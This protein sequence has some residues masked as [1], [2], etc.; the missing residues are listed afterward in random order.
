MQIF[1]CGPELLLLGEKEKLQCTKAGLGTAKS[2]C[3]FSSRRS[4]SQNSYENVVQSSGTGTFS[5]FSLYTFLT[6][7]SQTP[8]P[9]RVKPPTTNK[10]AMALAR[11]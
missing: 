4:G 9:A 11:H 5:S 1:G 2:N 8:L 10:A 6:F 3:L 7:A